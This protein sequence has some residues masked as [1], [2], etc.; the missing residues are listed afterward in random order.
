M[1]IVKLMFPTCSYSFKT[2]FSE[3]KRCSEAEPYLNSLQGPVCKQNAGGLIHQGAVAL[4]QHHVGD[5][6]VEV[7]TAQD[8]R[9]NLVLQQGVL[10]QRE[11]P[12]GFWSHD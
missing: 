6:L 3:Y 8:H 12:T 4:R 11:I 2:K 5:V 7:I 9:G 1:V 10:D